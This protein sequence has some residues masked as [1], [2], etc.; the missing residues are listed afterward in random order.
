MKVTCGLSKEESHE[1]NELKNERK[2]ASINI[3][4]K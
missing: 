1:I 2:N 3:S 4:S